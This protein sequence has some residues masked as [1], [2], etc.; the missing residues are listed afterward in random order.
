M[1]NLVG[2][3]L[4]QP[5]LVKLQVQRLESEIQDF[6]SKKTKEPKRIARL[7]YGHC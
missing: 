7:G 2:A 1:S 3:F 5:Q 6:G 4:K